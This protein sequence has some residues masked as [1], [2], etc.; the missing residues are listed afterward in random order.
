LVVVGNEHEPVALVY[1]P[2]KALHPDDGKFLLVV[3]FAV[4][5]YLHIYHIEL[6][7]YDKVLMVDNTKDMAQ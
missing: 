2:S 3:I 7:A 4:Y 6:Q 5:V 1:E